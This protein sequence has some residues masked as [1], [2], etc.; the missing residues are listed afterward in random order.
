MR[1]CNHC[2]PYI[3]IVAL[4]DIASTDLEINPR[5]LVDYRGILLCS[6][7]PSFWGDDSYETFIN[8]SLK[9]SVLQTQ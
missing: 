4:M 8:P 7:I 2:F 3:K 5:Q 6:L 9:I 1:L